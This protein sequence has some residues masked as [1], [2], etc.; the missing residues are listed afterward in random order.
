MEEKKDYSKLAIEYSKR[1]KGKIELKPT[2]K[3]KSLEDLS[4]VYTPG[5]AAVSTAISKDNRLAWDLT[6]RW[7][8]VF[9]VTNGTRVLGLGD[10]GPLASLPVMEGKSLIYKEFGGVN[11]VPI[12]IEAREVDEFVNVVKNISVTSGGIHLED[13]ESP[14]CFEVL[15]RLQE[16]L[17]VPV[18]HDDQQGTAAA[19]LAGLINATKLADKDLKKSRIIMIGA[20]AA[21]IALF[22]VLEKYGIDTGNIIIGDSKG[23]LYG[24]RDDV[25]IIKT[26]NRWKYE[27]M[28]K[29]NKDSIMDADKTFDGADIVVGF[30]R[31]GAIKPEWIKRM[32]S[33]PI[34]FANANP[35]PEILP[36]TAYK[37]GAYIVSTGRSDYPNQI[38]NSLIFPAV[39]R[40]ILDSKAAKIDDFTAI[41]AAEELAAFAQEKGLSK[42]YIVPNMEEREIYP[43]ISARVAEDAIKRGLSDLKE[44]KE[45]FYNK[46]KEII[47]LK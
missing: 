42:D 37:A 5:V 30:S 13:I 33:K 25:E 8:T 46:A 6:W 24:S 10:I 31:E 18:W 39:F 28:K 32:N 7:N 19:T 1:Y 15:E 12:P 23:P 3:I 29:S 17:K 47:G 22:R 36:E 41:A 20:G 14:F 11:A 35:N 34:V 4:I 40:G 16:E 45:Y 21:N 9:I 26:T 38:N 27:V 43:R 2:L 44:E